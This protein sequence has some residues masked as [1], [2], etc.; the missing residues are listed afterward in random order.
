MAETIKYDTELNLEHTRNGR[1][2]CPKEVLAKFLSQPA[3]NRVATLG[4]P[5]PFDPFIPDFREDILQKAGVGTIDSIVENGDTAIATLNLDPKLPASKALI[6][7]LKSGVKF[8][9][10]YRGIGECLPNDENAYQ[11]TEITSVAILPESST[12]N[13]DKV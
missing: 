6:E 5:K 10:G 1:H 4:F 2:Y 11:L 9:F 8:S 13:A 3:S 12:E 7:M